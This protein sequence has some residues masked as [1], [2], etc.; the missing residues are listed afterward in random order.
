[1]L[2]F[3]ATQVYRLGGVSHISKAGK[4]LVKKVLNDPT[5]KHYLIVGVFDP[6]DSNRVGEFIAV[7][8]PENAKL[9]YYQTWDAFSLGRSGQESANSIALSR[10]II[11]K[12]RLD[13]NATIKSLTTNWPAIVS[14]PIA[15]EYFSQLLSGHSSK[16]LASRTIA[17]IEA[18]ETLSR[19]VDLK[20]S[21]GR[22]NPS[23]KS[24]QLV[25]AKRLLKDQLT[26]DALSLHS[27]RKR[28]GFSGL[29]LDTFK[30][31]LI[32]L[33][34][35][36]R[37][38]PSNV[39]AKQLEHSAE[40]YACNPFGYGLRVISYNGYL[41]GLNRLTARN[42]I[43][44]TFFIE[45]LLGEFSN[46]LS[47]AKNSELRGLRPNIIAELKT[48]ISV[49]SPSRVYSELLS[50]L[51]ADLDE[52]GSIMA[53]GDDKAL[54]RKIAQTK[55]HLRWRQANPRGWPN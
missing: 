35:L 46:T 44:T 26:F 32:W 8:R 37:Y 50:L 55:K 43:R 15:V 14:N 34:S 1:M 5:H 20:D 45:D 41:N 52:L 28:V 23:A 3:G 6:R 42:K 54:K 10:N 53:D 40:L 19:V 13:S 51:R 27:A 31:E 7:V 4:Y 39:V 38:G 9:T 30:Q 21:R 11:E 36:L 25:K 22:F 47:L 16:L 29:V 33:D 12:I 17:R 18:G 24:A 49:P 2:E 48:M